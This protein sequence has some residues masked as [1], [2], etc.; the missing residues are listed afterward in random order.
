MWFGVAMKEKLVIG[1]TGM[2]GSG[3][4]TV[5]EIAET[6]G[7]LTVI[8]GN[9][10]REEAKRRNIEPTPENL[11]ALMLKLREEEGLAAIAKRC[12][13]KIENAKTSIVVVDGVRSQQ[14]I[15]E[16]KRYA[17]EFTLIAVH[18][19]PKTRFKRLS[20]R[21]RPDAP[22]DWQTFLE[23]D[24]RELNVGLGAVIAMADYMVVNEGTKEQAKQEAR[25]V[26]EDAIGRW[27]K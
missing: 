10:V 15:D 2:S 16:F 24:L 11:G 21:L 20:N 5:K 13:P 19:S 26:L 8:M 25:N 14:E 12:V 7:Y 3:K 23:R 22:R 4:A 9:E 1:V 17:K 6:M 27:M 18:A